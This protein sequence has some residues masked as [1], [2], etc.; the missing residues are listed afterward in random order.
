MGLDR[1]Q[2][3]FDDFKQAMA[4]ELVLSLPD[5]SVP[6]EVH[7]DVSDHALGGVLVQGHSIAFESKRLKDA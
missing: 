7:T 6:F 4:S 5:F 1:N 3:A 2:C